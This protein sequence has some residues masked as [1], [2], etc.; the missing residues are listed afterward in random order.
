MLVKNIKVNSLGNICELSAD[1]SS[2]ALPKPFTL[3][4]RFPGECKEYINPNNGNPFLAAALLLAMRTGE[5]L[6]ISKPVSYRLLRNADEPSRI[7]INIPII[8][9]TRSAL[10]H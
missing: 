6:Q 3:W 9:L 2:K 10:N 7:S 1:I 8:L 4:Y 5:E